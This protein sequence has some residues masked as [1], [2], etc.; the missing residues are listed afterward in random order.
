MPTCACMQ[1]NQEVSLH[2]QG[3]MGI[4]GLYFPNGPEFLILLQL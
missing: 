3:I 2:P 4:L 1:I